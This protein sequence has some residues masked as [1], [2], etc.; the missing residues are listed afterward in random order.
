MCGFVA[1]IID[2][3]SLDAKQKKALEKSLQRRKQ[4]LEARIKDLD[5]ALKRFG[6]S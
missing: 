4:E 2:I 3:K 5:R 1:D 6:K